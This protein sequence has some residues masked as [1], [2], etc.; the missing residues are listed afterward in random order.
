MDH[1]FIN[2]L[3]YNLSAFCSYN[4]ERI[5]YCPKILRNLS[6]SLQVEE[7]TQ[8]IKIVMILRDYDTLLSHIDSIIININNPTGNSFC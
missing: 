7:G 4:L 3:S 1:C 2:F 6:L 8:F 5:V